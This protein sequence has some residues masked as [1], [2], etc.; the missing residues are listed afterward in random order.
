MLTLTPPSDTASLSAFVTT[1]TPV[2]R[3]PFVFVGERLWLDFVNCE[4]G[5]RR[6]EHVPPWI[7][8][9][10]RRGRSELE[11]EPKRQPG[12]RPDELER[13]AHLLLARRRQRQVG[14]D[15]RRRKQDARPTTSRFLTESNALRDRS[16]AVIARRDDV[17]VDVDERR[18]HRSQPSD[19]VRP[20]RCAGRARGRARLPGARAGPGT[21]AGAHARV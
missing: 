2:E 9:Q 8:V 6:F 3:S 17:T 15:M 7:L 16:G 18:E 4:H 5:V 13:L 19:P 20:T 12:T 1:R 10:E 14:P 21:R 11:A